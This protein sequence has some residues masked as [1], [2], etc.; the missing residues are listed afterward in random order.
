MIKRVNK[1]VKTE[2]CYLG[3]FDRASPVNDPRIP[4][5]ARRVLT[6]P[7]TDIAD[8][9]AFWGRFQDRGDLL[10]WIVLFD[11]VFKGEFTVWPE[12]TPREFTPAQYE[13]FLGHETRERYLVCPTGELIIASL[14]ELGSPALEPAV[15]VQPGVYQLGLTVDATQEM[16]HEFLHDPDAYPEDDG[17]D[18]VIEMQRI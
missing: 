9:N 7:E 4:W 17:P 5:R 2:G 14:R 16:E 18:F 3:I 11:G 15:T 6:H 8:F 1:L 12:E 10:A 13:P